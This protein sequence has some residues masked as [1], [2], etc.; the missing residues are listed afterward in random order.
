P[1]GHLE[2][3]PKIKERKVVGY[4]C[5]FCVEV[6][7]TLRAICNHLRKHVQYG[8]VPSV[9]AA[10][11]GLR[12][13]ERS[14]LALAMFTRE[15]KYSCQYCSF[16]SAFRHNLDRHMQTHHGH[17]KPFR[18]KLCSFKSSYNSR[19]KTH[20]LKAHAGEHAYKC[21]WCSFSTVTISQLKEHS[22]KVHGK[23]LT[24]PRP[25]IVSLLSSHAHHS[26]QKAATAEEVEDS[27][28]QLC[29]RAD[30]QTVGSSLLCTPEL[31]A[32]KR[33]LK[34]MD[35]NRAVT[36]DYSI[37]LSKFHPRHPFLVSVMHANQAFSGKAPKCS[38]DPLSHLGT[39]TF[40]WNS[41]GMQQYRDMLLAGCHRILF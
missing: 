24:L 19:L 10:V 4:K 29:P 35:S 20:I 12:S 28:D 21:S 17:H 6:H 30:L 3:V 2:E 25:R 16:V 7:P 38:I 33:E 14:H 41:G 39:V 22:L 40:L 1:F 31:P 11:K 8:N 34:V 23:A 37:S 5:K 18:C 13:H 36:S 9:S 26:S 15:D 27:N 32:S